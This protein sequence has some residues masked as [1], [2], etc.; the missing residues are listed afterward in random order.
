MY[1]QLMPPDHTTEAGNPDETRFQCRHVYTDGHRCGS[2]ALKEE[3]FCY[4]H[5][6][7]R[8]PIQDPARRRRRQSRFSVPLPEDR[9]AIQLTI[10]QVLQ[11]LANNDLDPRRA[12]LLLYGLQIA[13]LNLPKHDPKADPIEPV[14]EIV[15]DPTHGAIALPEEYIGPSEQKGSAEILLERLRSIPVSDPEPPAD[16]A[17]LWRD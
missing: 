10:G 7:S 12:G 13:S 5:H 11:K 4:F 1:Q 15:T 2:P 17:G 9:S 16:P 8:R 6:T 14:N 3:N